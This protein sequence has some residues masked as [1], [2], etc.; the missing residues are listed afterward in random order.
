MPQ[1]HRALLLI[2]LLLVSGCAADA[3]SRADRSDPLISKQNKVEFVRLDH[4]VHFAPGSKVL[5]VN[6]ADALAG[7]LKG[8]AVGDGDKVTIDRAG[9]GALTAARQAT[10]LAVLKRMRV[11]VALA[12]AGADVALAPN[13]VR[14]RVARSVVTAPRCPDWTKPEADEPTNSP[15]SNFGCATESSLALM[16]ANPADLVR[17]SPAPGADGEALARGVEL[18]RS[19]AISKSL[20]SSGAS[21]GGSGASGSGGTGGGGQ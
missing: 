1:H 12:T 8:S 13:A 18:Y 10:V 5:A 20:A 3:G 6:E 2:G 21:A 7:F 15:S 14:V 17:G 19:G 11:P 4:D 9:S 16:V